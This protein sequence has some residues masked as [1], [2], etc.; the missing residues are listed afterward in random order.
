MGL[1]GAFAALHLFLAISFP[2]MLINGN[3]FEKDLKDLVPLFY[4]LVDSFGRFVYY[5]NS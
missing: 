4:I 5:E 3:K 1:T 2:L